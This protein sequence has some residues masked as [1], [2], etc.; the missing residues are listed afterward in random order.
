MGLP[1]DNLIPVECTSQIE[2]RYRVE[3]EASITQEAVQCSAILRHFSVGCACERYLSWQRAADGNV[4]KLQLN[5]DKSCQLPQ[6]FV[7]HL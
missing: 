1:F 6:G 5:L 4:G 3:P 7:L 2:R